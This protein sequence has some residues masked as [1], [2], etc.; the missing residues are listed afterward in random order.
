MGMTHLKEM[1]LRRNLHMHSSHS[2][3]ECLFVFKSW[4]PELSAQYTLLETGI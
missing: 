3:D 2:I 4:A 1:T